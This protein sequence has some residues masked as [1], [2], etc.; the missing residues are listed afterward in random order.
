MRRT[1][2]TW[3]ITHLITMMTTM[4]ITMVTVM[5]ITIVVQMSM[6]RNYEI[7]RNI[8]FIRQFHDM[9]R[10]LA[11]RLSLT[12]PSIYL[13]T[14]LNHTTIIIQDIFNCHTKAGTFT[15]GLCPIYISHWQ[16]KKALKLIL[17]IEG[18]TLNM[19][20]IFVVFGWN[21]LITVMLSHLHF[22]LDI[23]FARRVVELMNRK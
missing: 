3:Q 1:N 5:M 18:L 19:L 11:L 6:I 17:L 10:R 7:I 22:F 13:S 21:E 8:K 20:P 4:G 14:P 2:Y 12:R 9:S 23:I 16:Q 15:A